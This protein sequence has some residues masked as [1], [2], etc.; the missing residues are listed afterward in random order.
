MSSFCTNRR[1]S[2]S[3]H[4]PSMLRTRY[5]TSHKNNL[6]IDDFEVRE[7]LKTEN[8]EQK[9]ENFYYLCITKLLRL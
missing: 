1:I 3:S 6:I 9:T 5:L 4:T 8:I 2:S 7:K